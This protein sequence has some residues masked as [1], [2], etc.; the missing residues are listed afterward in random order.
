MLTLPDSIT[1]D[2]VRFFDTHGYWISPPIIDPSTLAELRTHYYRILSGE[3][4]TSVSPLKRSHQPGQLDQGVVKI[5]NC[6]LSDSQL[7]RLILHPVIG[8][9]ASLLL[10][11]TTVRY[12]R[13]HLWYKPPNSGERGNVGWHQDYPYW[14]CATPANLITA[15]IALGDVDSENGCLEYLPG[16]HR[17]GFLSEGDLYNHDMNALR[18]RIVEE[19]GQSFEPAPAI[20]PAGS[21]SFHHCL[22]VHGSRANTS[23]KP[24]LSISVHYMPEGTQYRA[25]TPSE[26]FLNVQFLSGTD[27]DPFVGP[28]FPVVYRAGHQAN[29]WDLE[30]LH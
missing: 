30:N 21:I 27:G 8:Q 20:M 6:Y 12:W 25:G 29:P 4:E 24:R 28:F 7:S 3:Y 22:T 17:W 16:S 2:T 10:Q 11:V 14:Q 15:W 26:S 9:I 19:T 13:D 1:E 23:L 5:T 18:N